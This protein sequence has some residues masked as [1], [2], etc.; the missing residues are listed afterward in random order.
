MAKRIELN[1]PIILEYLNNK[2]WLA[3]NGITIGPSSGDATKSYSFDTH[4][5]SEPI[6]GGNVYLLNGEVLDPYAL[7]GMIQKEEDNKRRN[8]ENSKSIQN[9]LQMSANP[10]L[11]GN[12]RVKLAQRDHNNPYYK[13]MMEGQN[14][15]GWGTIIAMAPWLMQSAA[16]SAIAS[17][18]N[19]IGRSI[20][21]GLKGLGEAMTPSNYIEAFETYG[22]PLVKGAYTTALGGSTNSLFG[23]FLDSAVAA[24][25]GAEA[26]NYFKKYPSLTSGAIAALM[27][28]PAFNAIRKVLPNASIEDIAKVL[29]KAAENY[30]SKITPETTKALETP[31]TIELVMPET[32]KLLTRQRVIRPW[33]IK[34]RISPG[35][36]KTLTFTTDPSKYGVSTEFVRQVGPVA[37]SPFNESVTAIY[38]KNPKRNYYGIKLD[39]PLTIEEARQLKEIMPEEI[40]NGARVTTY[41]NPEYN[42]SSRS[43]LKYITK[44]NENFEPVESAFHGNP[45][46]K[47]LTNLEQ[48]T[49]KLFKEKA[50]QNISKIPWWRT[51]SAID[52]YRPLLNHVIEDNPMPFENG[53]PVP[54]ENVAPADLELQG[55]DNISRLTAPTSTQVPT[56]RRYPNTPKEGPYNFQLKELLEGNPLENLRSVKKYGTI[57]KKDIVNYFNQ[58][59]GSKER[60]K[61]VNYIIETVLETKFKAQENINYNDFLDAV[62]DE[63]IQGYNLEK[64]DQYASYM[65]NDYGYMNNGPYHS[66]NPAPGMHTETYLFSH[67]NMPYGS[68]RHFKN[69]TL[70]HVRVMTLDED[71]NTLIILENQSDA[72]QGAIQNYLLS[73]QK[74]YLLNNSQLRQFQEIMKLA[75][76]QG[77]SRILYPTEETVAKIQGYSKSFDGLSDKHQSL[78]D[79]LEGRT[80]LRKAP[81]LSEISKSDSEL[82]KLRNELREFQGT[83]T[84]LDKNISK[85]NFAKRQDLK[86]K[87]KELDNELFKISTNRDK[88][89]S[90]IYSRYGKIDYPQY[91]KSIMRKY[92]H[93]PEIYRKA[94]GDNTPLQIVTDSKGNTY[95]E[96]NVPQDYLDRLWPFKNGGKLIKRKLK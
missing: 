26:Y 44:D 86:S 62:K 75:A 88:L 4:E 41:G 57:S 37:N 30:A 84:I 59:Q 14:E 94:T 34:H 40:P 31:T 73:P 71:P 18:V 21:N 70:G 1:D 67:P 85:I 69:N 45:V 80:N 35:E 58:A 55:L 43:L 90:Y 53:I 42:E 10:D 66:Y 52:Q 95:Y 25:F 28:L 7:V 50:N 48:L 22:N 19:T 12:T 36:E 87:I 16:G 15:A 54:L 46:V 38:Q 23:S 63:L 39:A 8:E 2:D 61:A 47:K 91:A 9:K 51:K 13:A 6:K 77:K 24:K 65:H 76:K 32:T 64:T 60:K 72:G 96:I 93:F 17:G 78:L 5:F 33:S 89:K 82:S 29:S 49:N 3:N 92:K 81:I 11:F 20:A 74:N 56:S 68:S 79:K 27:N 83:S